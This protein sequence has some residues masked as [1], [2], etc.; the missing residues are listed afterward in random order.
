V[1]ADGPAARVE[2]EQAGVQSS[3]ESG[4]LAGGQASVVASISAIPH[5]RATGVHALRH[6][7]ASTLLDAGEKIWALAPYLG[8]ADPGFTLRIYTHLVPSDAERTGQAVDALFGR[9][10]L[11]A[12]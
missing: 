4:G 11:A 10:H 1:H 6:S 9:S 7:Y 5:T 3:S 8:H 12:A 2:Q